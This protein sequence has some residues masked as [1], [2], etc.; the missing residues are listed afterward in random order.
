MSPRVIVNRLLNWFSVK[1]FFQ[2]WINQQ[3]E[4]VRFQVWKKAKSERDFS[5]NSIEK[6]RE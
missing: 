5:R 6:W 2:N 3:K 4:Q 1:D